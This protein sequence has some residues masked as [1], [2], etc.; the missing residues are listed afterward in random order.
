MKT[1]FFGVAGGRVQ[2]EDCLF[3]GVESPE[4][5]FT[6]KRINDGDVCEMMTWPGGNGICVTKYEAHD[7]KRESD[8]EGKNVDNVNTQDRDTRSFL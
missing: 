5:L 2:F 7:I 1:K 3:D 4:V 8:V 6:H